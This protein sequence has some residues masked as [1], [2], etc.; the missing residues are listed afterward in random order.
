MAIDPTTLIS[1]ERPWLR[2]AIVALQ[3]TLIVAPAMAQSKPESAGRVK[4]DEASPLA[5]KQTPAVI[6]DGLFVRLAKAQDAIEAKGVA[7]Q[8]ERIWSKSGSDTADLLMSRVNQSMQAKNYDLAL[9]LLDSI[10]A[11]EPHWAEAWNRRATVHFLREDADSSMRDI[12]QVLA[13]EP[14]HYGAIAG[15]SLIFQNLEDGKK[16]YKAAKAALA[17]YPFME[18][19]KEYVERHAREVEGEAL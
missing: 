13:L 11:L 5:Q 16:A 19:A 9:D 10:I 14:R 8:I 1:A 15:M 3:L 4:P 7:D 6:L 2:S 17:I 12:R 18:G